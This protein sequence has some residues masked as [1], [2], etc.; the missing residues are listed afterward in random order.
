LHFQ[1]DVAAQDPYQAL[2]VSRAASQAEIKSAY[3]ELAKKHHPDLNPGS[4]EAERKFKEV[5]AAYAR[6]GDPESRAKFDRGEDEQ[7]GAGDFAGRGPFYRE[8]QQGPAGQTGG[9]TGGRYTYQFGAGFDEDLF[10]SI[11]GGR[12]GGRAK[13]EDVL[14]RMEVDLRDSVLGGEREVTLPSGKRISVRIPP[15]VSDGSRLRFAGL[16][17]AGRQDAPPGDAYVEI[18]VRPDPRFER[19]GNDLVMKLPISLAQAVLG[20]EARARTLDGEVMLRVPQG[21]SSGR[22]LRLAGKG[23]FDRAAGKRGDL[24]V[25]LRI[26]LPDEVDAEL[27]EAI[28]QWQSRHPYEPGRA[29]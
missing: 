13:G 28:R 6:I 16:G 1:C 26:V 29:A 19:Q 21:S 9:Q 3:R 23:A 24:F 2:G 18:R 25:E 7:P 12:A 10:E 14:Y 22:R 17:E 15:G 27:K 4:K 20:G 5:A 11:F 8:T